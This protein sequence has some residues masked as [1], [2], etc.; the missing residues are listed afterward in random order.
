MVCATLFA[1]ISM[2]FLLAAKFQ[3]PVDPGAFEFGVERTFEGT[4][5]ESPL[6]VL[7]INK[8]G[9]KSGMNFLLV[10]SGKFRVPEVLRGKDG[11]HVR[12]KG[13]LI[14]RNGVAMIEVNKPESIE[15]IEGPRAKAPKVI[16]LGQGTFVGE[17]VDTK[18]FL[19]VMRPATGKV[20]RGCA[21]RCLSGGAP[22]GLL[23]RDE[24]GDS[25]ALLL[26]GVDG[27][28]L[29]IDWGLAARSLK[30]EGDFE[31]HSGTPILRVRSW[32]SAD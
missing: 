18:C 31:L 15:L 19:G 30:V 16:S 26:A 8:S 14:Y 29:D 23:V 21:I 5:F 32:R 25:V 27:K 28:R 7:Q 20:H 6:T 10:G 3:N 11:Q 4:L 24:R 2:L 22:P 9:A 17:L 13:S 12:F 1:A